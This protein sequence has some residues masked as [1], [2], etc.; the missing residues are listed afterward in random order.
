MLMDVGGDVVEDVLLRDR[1]IHQPDQSYAD[2][3]K[4]LQGAQNE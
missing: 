2:L 3:I 1:A 4:G